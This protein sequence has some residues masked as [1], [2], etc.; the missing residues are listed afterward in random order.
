MGIF[1]G[2][3]V[4]AADRATAGSYPIKMVKTDD[5]VG[6][7]YSSQ[8]ATFHSRDQAGRQAEKYNV[9]FEP[10][11]PDKL[12]FH[13]GND[14]P[15]NPAAANNGI[16]NL[17]P[18][19]APKVFASVLEAA[20]QHLDENPQYKS[21]EIKADNSET[22]R[23]KLYRALARRFSSTVEETQDG[24]YTHFAMPRS[25]IRGLTPP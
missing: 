21:V 14:D 6:G 19:T 9:Y 4:T 22:S 20:K 10:H 23:V 12:E 8:M 24:G 25:A 11:G 2:K 1:G 18:R 3:G 13:F 17:E 7:A 16:T 15:M 5:D